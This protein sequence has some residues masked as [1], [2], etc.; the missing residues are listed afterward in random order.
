MN[1]TADATITTPQHPATASW[2]EL[3]SFGLDSAWLTK[4]VLNPAHRGVRDALRDVNTMHQTL[5]KIVCPAD[6]GPG[7]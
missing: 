5:M 1:D 4:L 3:G 6:F 2:A 7:S